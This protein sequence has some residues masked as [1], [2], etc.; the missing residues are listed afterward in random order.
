VAKP[1]PGRAE[2]T[3]ANG[4]RNHER[5]RDREHPSLLFEQMSSA[6]AIGETLFDEAG[7]P[8]TTGIIDVNPAYERLTGRGPIRCRHC[9][10]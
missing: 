3:D 7:K 8:I 1:G 5:G 9:M 2:S 6:V 4:C 10:L